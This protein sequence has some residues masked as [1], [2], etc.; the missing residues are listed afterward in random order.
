MMD[1]WFEEQ[2]LLVR[3]SIKGKEEKEQ[4]RNYSD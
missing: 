4:R 2:T 1:H 3:I